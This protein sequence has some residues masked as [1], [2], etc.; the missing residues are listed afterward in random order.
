M[1]GSVALDLEIG[2][3][4]AEVLDLLPDHP[5][6]YRMWPGRVAG[7]ANLQGQLDYDGDERTVVAMGVPGKSGSL[8]SAGVGGVDHGQQAG[9]GTLGHQ[10]V[11]PLEDVIVSLLARLITQHEL[12]KSVRGE[13]GVRREVPGGEG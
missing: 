13:D 10:L 5:C 2:L 6:R 1:D 4:V 12:T 8:R 3:Q 7:K 11:D 9:G